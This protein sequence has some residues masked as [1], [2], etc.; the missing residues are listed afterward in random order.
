MRSAL[1]KAGDDGDLGWSWKVT[2]F[3]SLVL[4]SMWAD[5]PDNRI[6]QVRNSKEFRQWVIP[7]YSLYAFS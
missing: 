3:S 2:L 4:S 7:I 5:H 6:K 1:G